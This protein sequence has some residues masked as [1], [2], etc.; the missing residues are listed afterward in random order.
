MGEHVHGT[1]QLWV[2]MFMGL[3]IIMGE[4]V[5]GTEKLEH[6]YG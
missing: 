5:H 6:Y 3:N 4:H 1:E 2:S